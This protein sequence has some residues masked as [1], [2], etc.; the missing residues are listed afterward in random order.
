MFFMDR[1][2]H[3]AY[4]L[5]HVAIALLF[6]IMLVS[7]TGMATTSFVSMMISV[8]MP[9]PVFLSVPVSMSF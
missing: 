2:R 4:F 6:K 9:M 3:Q 8:P 5:T 1:F 7:I